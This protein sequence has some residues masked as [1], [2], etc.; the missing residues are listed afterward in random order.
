[1]FIAHKLKEENIAE[2]LLYMW[3]IEDLIRAFHLDIDIINEKIIRPYPISDDEKKQLYEWYESLIDMMRR[4]NLQEKG[5]LQLNK[6]IIILLDE[7]HHL[8]LKSGEDAGYT[9]KY[10]HVLPFI[11]QLKLQ[12]TDKSLS[13]IEICFNF[14]YGI[15]MLKLEK[16]EITKETQKAQ[17]EIA[18]FLSLLA[19]DYKKTQTGELVFEED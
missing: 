13:D 2:Y 9:A 19:N 12:N 5:H 10:Y 17:T 16:K 14:Q 18:K 11:Q 15:M 7:L 1:M 4:E 3:Q 8:L 6:N